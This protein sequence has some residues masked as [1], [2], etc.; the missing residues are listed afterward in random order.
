MLSSVRKKIVF[1]ILYNSPWHSG[2]FSCSI[3]CWCSLRSNTL[4]GQMSTANCK[5]CIWTIVWLIL[6]IITIKQHEWYNRE[7][8]LNCS[9]HCAYIS[10]ILS[11]ILILFINTSQEFQLCFIILVSAVI[12]TLFLSW[13][14]EMS[15]NLYLVSSLTSLYQGREKCSDMV[16][17][18]W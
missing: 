18:S 12:L 2:P 14:T 15:A 9:Q 16:L 10:F 11:L 7:K 17:V 5:L 6:R 1:D 13:I 4:I 8:W 3:N